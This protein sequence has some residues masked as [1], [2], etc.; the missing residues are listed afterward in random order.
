M[1][2]TW[3]IFSQAVT[4]AVAVLFVV[5][6]LK[7]DWLGR[8]TSFLP[9]PT[10]IQAPAPVGAAAS[11]AVAATAGVHSFAA[12]ARAALP[13]VVSI[14][15][16][17]GAGAAMPDDPLHRGPFGNPQRRA[18][19]GLGSGV[20]VSPEGYLLTNHHVV[21]GA[22][23]IDVQL[24]DGRGAR[25]RL[26]GADAETDIAVLRIELDDLPVV[27]LGDPSQLQVGDPV[28]AIGSPFNLGQTV[29]AGIVSAL[30]RNRLRLSTY[31]DFIQTDAA[32]N[33]GNSGGALVDA[34]GALV[35]IN[36][37]IF[38]RSGGSQG[39][40]F[41]VPVDLARDVMT[42]LVRDGRVVRGWIG[43]EIVAVTAEMAD[44]LNLP[45][46]EG[47]LLSGVL[48]DGPSAAAGLRP[49]DVVLR[50][51]DQPV[52]SDV[53]FMRRVAALSPGSQ[54]K[55]SLQRGREVLTV[56]VGVRQR[57]AAVRR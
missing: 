47:V 51:A 21:A 23:E 35:G 20:I 16:Q 5:A 24:A 45:V 15:A 33:P 13:A 31:E 12:A 14:T 9:T 55:L 25:A 22:D 49:G 3:L 32:I 42:A 46:R 50:V 53:D 10:L 29:T 4:V 43:V 19:V 27:A 1:F 7:P 54:V 57:P 48:Q 18:Q 34:R 39:I 26:I 44:S 28:L 11:G 52:R 38:S 6:T 40:G 37:A 30:G 17:R 41:A 2:R 8:R 56:D 36:T